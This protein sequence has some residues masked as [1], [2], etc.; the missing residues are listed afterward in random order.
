MKPANSAQTSQRAA[1]VRIAILLAVL[2]IAAFAG[3]IVNQ[4]LHVHP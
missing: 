3:T 4:S 1:N 2:A